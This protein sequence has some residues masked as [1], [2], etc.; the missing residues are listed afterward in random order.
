M[1]TK[2][3]FLDALRSGDYRQGSGSLNEH[4][5]FCC[6]GVYCNLAAPGKW[7]TQPYGKAL[8][9][10]FAE[11]SSAIDGHYAIR[12][13]GTMLGLSAD[14]PLS[15]LFR[16]QTHLI[17]MNDGVE[18]FYGRRHTFDEIADWIEDDLPHFVEDLIGDLRFTRWNDMD[19]ATQTD[20]ERLA[21]HA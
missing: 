11:S 4:G 9:S 8:R 17:H 14:V 18:D 5:N 6:L 12:S 21:T 19:V 13:F 7:V 2:D 10:L 1:V 16:V 3:E 20:A 15:I